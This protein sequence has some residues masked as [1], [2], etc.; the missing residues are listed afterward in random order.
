MISD[1]DNESESNDDG[2]DSSISS[3]S[4]CDRHVSEL[5]NDDAAI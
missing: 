5:L 1:T 3:Y 2:D 4:E